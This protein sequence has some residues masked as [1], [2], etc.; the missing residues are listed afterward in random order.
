[1]FGAAN[2]VEKERIDGKGGEQEEGFTVD[3]FDHAG[4]HDS[5]EGRQEA[6]S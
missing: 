6:E 2:P 3:E 4:G 5:G 1:M